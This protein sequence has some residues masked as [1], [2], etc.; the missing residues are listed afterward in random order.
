MLQSNKRNAV[1]FESNEV[2]CKRR[3]MLGANA[4]AP[5]LW[6][7]EGATR[8]A[9][10]PIR[11]GQFFFGPRDTDN[12]QRGFGVPSTAF[13][14]NDGA[15]TMQQNNNPNKRRREHNEQG[16]SDLE[17][18]RAELERMRK[19]CQEQKLINQNMNQACENQQRELVR[20]HNENKLLKRSVVAFNE[21]RE[22]AEHETQR[23]RHE[24]SAAH[25]RVRELEE[26]NVRLFYQSQ[27][28][29]IH[30]CRDDDYHDRSPFSGG[31]P[32][33]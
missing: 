28:T 15:L 23:A 31:G 14:Q 6:G 22:H 2:T 26:A 11:N 32:V 5:G 29:S 27:Q 24:L 13:G 9:E 10:S 21:K 33:C 30:T 7:A 4:P 18:L 12:N 19:E 25:R 17:L 1:D 20:L 16:Q 3:R 8:T